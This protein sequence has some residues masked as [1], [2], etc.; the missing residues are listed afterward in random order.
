MKG[1]R[2]SNGRVLQPSN[3]Q[4]DAGPYFWRVI[5]ANKFKGRKCLPA[6]L[7]ELW[8][9]RMTFNYCQ[10]Y[11][12]TNRTKFSPF[13]SI[14]KLKLP[15]HFGMISSGSGRGDTSNITVY[16]V[17]YGRLFGQNTFC[18]G[19]FIRTSY[20][21]CYVWFLC[22]SHITLPGPVRTVP[23]LFW[24]KIVRPRTGPARAP[25]G[26]VRILPPRTGPVEF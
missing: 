8:T 24:T 21:R 6:Y 15:L 19:V 11:P 14:R 3:W 4:R 23:G 7:S 13:V 10:N 26:A 12:H 22:L 18:S 1:S 25:C 16:I 5:V 17:P 9:I 2:A 20:V